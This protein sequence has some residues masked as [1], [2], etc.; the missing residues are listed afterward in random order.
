MYLRF[1][2]G[3]RDNY[4]GLEAGVFGPAFDIVNYHIEVPFWHWKE[5]RQTLDWFNDNLDRPSR[6]KCR[7]RK[8]RDRAGVCWFRPEAER[9]ISMARY[10]RWLVS[11]A[12]VP[13]WEVRS[14]QPGEIVFRDDYQIVAARNR[15]GP[16]YLT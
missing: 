10:L 8:A 6:L 3:V 12:G 11:E 1:I 5:I 4:S 14:A 16:V 13:V 2:C 7:R 15:S 9:H